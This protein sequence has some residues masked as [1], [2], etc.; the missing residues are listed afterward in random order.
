MY[1]PTTAEGMLELERQDFLAKR[2]WIGM[3]GMTQPGGYEASMA[4][5]GDPE[6]MCHE[7]GPNVMNDFM[8]MQHQVSGQAMQQGMGDRGKDMKGHHHPQRYAPT[9]RP[10]TRRADQSRNFYGPGGAG[11]GRGGKDG[12]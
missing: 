7:Y 3:A 4:M 1:A 12:T 5:L 9:A 10:G 11:R 2:M 8:A 6:M